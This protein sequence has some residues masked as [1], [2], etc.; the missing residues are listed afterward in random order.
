[1]NKVDA[2]FE[3]VVAGGVT[4]VVTELIFLLIAQRRKQSD[5]RGELIV[6]ESFEAGNRQR[7]RAEG[8]CQGKAQ[9]RVAGLRE[10]QCAGAHYECAQPSRIE[11][12]GVAEDGV[13]V[14]VVG[15]QSGGRK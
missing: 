10:M 9:S 12:V 2:E 15:G 13:P 3:S 8:E 14:I 6:P 5:G 1:M 7:G 11:R 4:Y